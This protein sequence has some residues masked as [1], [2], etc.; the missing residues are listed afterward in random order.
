[1]FYLEM[2]VIF[3]D[4]MDDK[5]IM[6]DPKRG[7]RRGNLVFA[8]NT[9]DAR[10][11]DMKGF[12]SSIIKEIREKAIVNRKYAC[13]K[14]PSKD[15]SVPQKAYAYTGCKCNSVSVNES[16][17]LVKGVDE[18]RYL[19]M[20]SKYAMIRISREY[21]PLLPCSLET[22]RVDYEVIEKIG[23]DMFP[24]AVDIVKKFVS[25]VRYFNKAS[26]REVFLVE[27]PVL[28]QFR[29]NPY[30]MI[31]KEMLWGFS[32]YKR[33]GKDDVIEESW[34]T[35]RLTN[36]S[37]SYELGVHHVRDC[38][39]IRNFFMD[40]LR[41]TVE[42]GFNKYKENGTLPNVDNIRADIE[43]FMLYTYPIVSDMDIASNKAIV[44]SQ[45]E[46]AGSNI[47]Y[48][49]KYNRF[50]VFLNTYDYESESVIKLELGDYSS[51]LVAVSVYLYIKNKLEYLK[52]LIK[53]VTDPI[54]GD[55]ILTNTEQ[56]VSFIQATETASKYRPLY[57]DSLASKSVGITTSGDKWV[58]RLVID[59]VNR[60]KYQP[61]IRKDLGVFNKEDIEKA[62]ICYE[63]GFLYY[64]FDSK[65]NVLN[66]WSEA[67]EQEKQMLN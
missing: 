14:N 30:T 10:M 61:A 46:K 26:G 49:K 13:A 64:Y 44:Y 29:L 17:D 24:L 25:K 57:K 40:I 3:S 55:K 5:L 51:S 19:D 12:N 18:Q 27:H 8:K 66:Y 62:L 31:T 28:K 41:K 53:T 23:V 9:A 16:A 43:G 60:K 32:A 33:Y 50:R 1:M 58:V 39:A 15:Y 45:L 63:A 11:K 47:K 56:Y 67:L 2:A 20:I 35:I 42:F 36:N 37:K 21:L 59:N 54:A 65:V 52:G 34:Y 6:V 4:G 38:I 7:L 22:N 48:L